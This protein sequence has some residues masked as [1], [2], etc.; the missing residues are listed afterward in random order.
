MSRPWLDNVLVECNQHFC[1]ANNFIPIHEYVLSG[2]YILH[3]TERKCLECRACSMPLRFRVASAL[4]PYAPLDFGELCERLCVRTDIFDNQ[5]NCLDCADC[6]CFVYM[7]PL[8]ADRL[9]TT[10]SVCLD[11]VQVGLVPHDGVYAACPMCGPG[12]RLVQVCGGGLGPIL[13][14]MDCRKYA[15]WFCTLKFISVPTYPGHP[16]RYCP[17]CWGPW[18]YLEAD[19]DKSCEQAM[20]QVTVMVDTKIHPTP[21]L[22]LNDRVLN[23]WSIKFTTEI[24]AA[25]TPAAAATSANCAPTQNLI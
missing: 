10:P 3:R 2:S 5:W 12:H 11:D 8:M 21:F 17:N 6:E 15:C 24:S 20:C 7:P 16:F 23:L 4:E 9:N 13:P 25:A 14:D 18:N 1:R 22:R 19:R